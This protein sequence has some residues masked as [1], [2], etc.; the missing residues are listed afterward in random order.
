MFPT[1]VVTDGTAELTVRGTTP[2]LV[3]DAV[4]TPA[5]FFAVTRKMYPLPLMSPVT[6]A[7]VA[8]DT[9]SLKVIHVVP[10]FVEYSMT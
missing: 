4:P 8:L 3:D 5:A 10:L 1:V 2:E 9:E 7:V 6:V